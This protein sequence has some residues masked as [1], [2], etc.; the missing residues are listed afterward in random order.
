MTGGR[1]AL[2]IRELKTREAGMVKTLAVA[3][4]ALMMLQSAL[5]SQE[6]YCGYAQKGDTLAITFAV[7]LFDVAVDSRWVIETRDTT[8]TFSLTG[9]AAFA[10]GEKLAAPARPFIVLA[11][12][13][14]EPAE[15]QYA[16]ITAEYCRLISAHLNRVFRESPPKPAPKPRTRMGAGEEPEA[17]PAP[18]TPPI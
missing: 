3:A 18:F 5:W 1:M 9:I 10:H 15:A 11:F 12:A 6:P 2:L 14:N 7:Y 17:R 16:R 4:V 8:R 13:N